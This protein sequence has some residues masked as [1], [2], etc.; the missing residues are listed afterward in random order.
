MQLIVHL[1]AFAVTLALY[2][3]LTRPLQSGIRSNRFRISTRARLIYGAATVAFPFII[4]NAWSL[5]DANAS[6][7]PYAA[8]IA[9]GLSV[10]FLNFLS[11]QVVVLPD[12]VLLITFLFK[13]E[14]LFSNMVQVRMAIDG[15][16]KIYTRKGIGVS[17]PLTI[18]D[19]DRLLSDLEKASVR[20][21][22]D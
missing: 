20:V 21:Y 2:F 9:G 3:Y 13:R 16:Y 14:I 7:R 5:P 18:V 22:R 19:L 10:Y 15:A 11:Q 6:H 12:R 8:I 17:L 1:S 4:F